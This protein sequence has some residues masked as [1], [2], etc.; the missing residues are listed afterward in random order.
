VALAVVA[1]LVT[2]G[3]GIAAMGRDILAI[4]WEV[5]LWGAAAAAMG[6]AAIPLA[7]GGQLGLDM[8]V[9]L[10]AGYVFG[11]IPAGLIAF[12]AYVDLRELRGAI[13]LHRALF[14]RAQTSLSVM[15]ATAVFWAVRAEA[16][17]W[18]GAVFGA[19]LAVSLDALM[20]V[21]LV[22]GV[23]ALHQRVP[24]AVALSKLRLGS[25]LEFVGTYASFGLLSLL[26]AENYLAVGPWS[27]LLFMTPAVLARNAF[28]KA[29]R[30]ELAERD[31]RTQRRALRK[32]SGS[33]AEERRDERLSIAADLHDD[34]LPSLFKVHLIGQVL[35]QELATGQLLAM[36]DD[37]PELVRATDEASEALRSLIHDL[38]ASPLG[39]G[40]LVHTLGL[41]VD[42]MK[43]ETSTKF[44]T[45]LQE[46]RASPVVELL[47]YQVSREALRNAVRHSKA[48][49]IRVSVLHEDD[50][51]RLIVEDDGIGFSPATVDSDSHFGLA[52]MRERAELVG[53]LLRIDTAVGVGTRVV[54]RLPATRPHKT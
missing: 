30:L 25:P 28:T 5:V 21:M 46:V 17:V 14:N 49:L 23:V 39:A 22:G 3:I 40:G 29:A 43:L 16:S 13:S 48:S 7:G 50:D 38:R 32:A 12:A 34:V 54:A 2:L 36:E 26:L 24:P 41:L 18:P 47:A 6:L 52:L 31:I 8:P 20:N 42:Q 27:L 10:A 35:R 33:V 45:D 1:D 4:W 51:I 53:G 11:P 9:L 19:L 37:L 44:E 15:G